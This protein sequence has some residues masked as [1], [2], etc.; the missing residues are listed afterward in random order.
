MP[1]AGKIK[2]N[3][4]IDQFAGLIYFLQKNNIFN[5]KHKPLCKAIVKLFSLQN[6]ED[7]SPDSLYNK[8]YDSVSDGDIVNFWRNKFNEYIRDSYILPKRKK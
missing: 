3:I 4:S 8:G 7:I 6:G 2:I 5:I 1:N